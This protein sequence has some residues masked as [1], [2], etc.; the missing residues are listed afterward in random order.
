MIHVKETGGMQ[1]LKRTKSLYPFWR[2]DFGALCHSFLHLLSLNNLVSIHLTSYSTQFRNK[3][4][5][6]EE[7]EVTCSESGWWGGG[8]GDEGQN[9][10]LYPVTNVFEIR[11]EA[12]FELQL[13][14]QVFCGCAD[15]GVFSGPV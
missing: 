6:T 5:G 10:C 13:S 8:W 12:P 14:L 7:N 15:Q 11:V 4:K 3:L 9:W 1:P 2:E